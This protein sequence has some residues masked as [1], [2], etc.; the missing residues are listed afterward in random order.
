MVFAMQALVGC[1]ASD[2]ITENAI[3]PIVLNYDKAKIKG[4]DYS[5]EVVN[6]EY[7]GIEYETYKIEIQPNVEVIASFDASNKV[8]KLETFSPFFR[9][10]DGAR[11]G[12][13]LDQL[14]EIYPGGRIYK[15]VSDA[16]LQF[17]F[18]GKFAHHVFMFD[19]NKIG[20]DCI[21]NEKDCP[22]DFGALNSVG[23][24]MYKM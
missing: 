3:G 19:A 2:Q 22:A 4:L 13:S 1:S 18:T 17:N 15:G 9:T 24:Y 20:A 11:I 12:M 5:Y 8:S 14:R 23:F 10:S 21:L 16:G 6:E 7:E